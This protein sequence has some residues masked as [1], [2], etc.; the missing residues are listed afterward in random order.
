MSPVQVDNLIGVS[1]CQVDGAFEGVAGHVDNESVLP[2]PKHHPL[3]SAGGVVWWPA[4]EKQ[5]LQKRKKTSF[6]QLSQIF[7]DT[8]LN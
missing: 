2:H 5:G 4:L 8:R 3:H 6:I 1:L 7:G